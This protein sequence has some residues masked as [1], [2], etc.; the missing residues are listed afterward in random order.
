MN[1]GQP[2][3]AALDTDPS[4]LDPM[5]DLESHSGQRLDCQNLFI[6]VDRW[7]TTSSR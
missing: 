7:S 6:D 3:F 5:P 1:V 2:F 4:G